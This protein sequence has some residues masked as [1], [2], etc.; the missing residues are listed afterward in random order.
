MHIPNLLTGQIQLLFPR[1]V[2]L[3]YSW[4]KRAIDIVVVILG[5]PAAILVIAGC[6]LAI[7]LKMG[8]P[9]FF[10][11]DRT[12]L[13]GRVFKMYKLRT[14]NPRSS[15]GG[16]ATS[17]DDPRVTPLGRF[18]RRSHF[19]ELPQL[20]NILKGDMTLI[21][22]RPEQPQLVAAYRSSLSDYDLRHTV[23]PGLTGCAQVYYGYASDLRETQ[24][25]LFYDLYYVHNIGPALDFQ[26]AMRTFR[27]YSDPHYVR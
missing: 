2:R 6:C 15:S 10:A 22:P 17:K 27:V 7:F 19:D 1:S 23:V 16:E 14:M 8:R 21:G 4:A 26:I 18:L 12:G 3:D 13:G 9:V 11:Q 25:K 20:W 5:A 24:A